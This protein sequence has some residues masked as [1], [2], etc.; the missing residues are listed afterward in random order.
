LSFTGHF[1]SNIISS[2]LKNIGIN[3]PVNS[4]IFDGNNQQQLQ[5]G[6]SAEE[7][8]ESDAFS[9]SFFDEVV[10]KIVD[11][12]SIYSGGIPDDTFDRIVDL[13]FQKFSQKER[14]QPVPAHFDARLKWPNC[15]SIGLVTHQGRC[16]SWYSRHLY[17]CLKSK[18]GF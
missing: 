6:F 2:S 10:D 1:L 16:G 5:K 3:L 9:D 14:A 4:F 12:E 15:K 17:S 8:T 7:T 18:N 11:D 13:P